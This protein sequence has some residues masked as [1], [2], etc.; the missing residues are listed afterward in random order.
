MASVSPGSELDGYGLLRAF[1]SPIPSDREAKPGRLPGGGTLPA[2]EA[3]WGQK[4]L[5][6]S[7]LSSLR[8]LGQVLF[9]NNPLSGLLLLSALLVQSAWMA[10]FA[11][12]GIL[13]ANLCARAIGAE[14]SAWS[15]GIYGFNAA[16]VG[17][18]VGA[19]AQLGDG[20]SVLA[21]LLVV[22]GGAAITTL[23]LDGPGRWL[24]RLAGLPP[25]T[26]PFCL[27]TWL[28]L[29]LAGSLAHPS[30]QLAL[31]PP[32]QSGVGG[33]GAL[34]AGLPRG[35]GQVL[36][37][38][39]LV[40]G[41][42]VLLA[43]AVAS[44]LA[45]LVGLLGG[46]VAGLVGLLIGAQPEAVA[47]GLW[48]YDGVLTAIA[49]AGTFYAPTRLSLAVALLGAA[50]ASLL[51][52]GLSQLLARAGSPG[53][54]LL[55][56]P[57]IL[58]TLAM[59]L[60]IRWSLPR[61]L[62]VALHALYTP[63]EHRRRFVVSRALLADFRRRLGATAAGGRHFLAPAAGLAATADAE[64]EG[65]R[66][67]R[68]LFRDL[69]RNGDGQLSVAELA[70]GLIQRRRGGRADLANR[71]LFNRL[72]QLL[73]SMDGD[74]DGAVSEDEFTALMLRLRRL[75]EGEEQLLRYLKPVDVNGDDQIDAGEMR[76]LLASVGQ[77]PL[78]AAEEQRLFGEAG[79][80]LSW[81]AFIDRLL[82]A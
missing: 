1:L 65:E 39:N 78:N 76:R 23:L 33:L 28:L 26:L 62:P 46:A 60:V 5:G 47:M 53:L 72:R 17:A 32:L 55:H 27:V 16:L 42:L 29:T 49:I 4:R 11:V 2:L 35:F 67:L 79:G 8:S 7:L 38:P 36:L 82:L 19:F 34:L 15:Q 80:R 25:L 59:V 40:S 41:V 74:G 3:R 70:T 12:V 58:A 57:F 48:S 37:C 63:E 52:P 51:T 43:T 56:L 21:W 9:L 64:G 24:F 66:L 44:P 71:T 31:Q 81:A 50:A 73:T 18:A 54:P 14:R 13:T 61:L 75:S 68:R 69:D 6:R 20:A 22:A 45:A 30:L 77:P 10:L